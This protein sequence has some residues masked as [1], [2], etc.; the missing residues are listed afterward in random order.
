MGNINR[1]KHIGVLTPCDKLVNF[2]AFIV[3]SVEKSYSEKRKSR[4]TK[5]IRSF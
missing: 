1:I 4:R 5:A 3:M 2:R